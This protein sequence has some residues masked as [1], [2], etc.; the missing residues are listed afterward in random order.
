VKVTTKTLAARLNLSHSTV[1]MALREHPLINYK[2][3]LRVQ[4]L[5]REMNYRPNAIARAMRSSMT[6][7]IGVLVCTMDD[8]FTAGVVNAIEHG[9]KQVDYQSILCQSHDSPEAL[10]KEIQLLAERRVDGL[11][12]HPFGVLRHPELP[13]LLRSLDIPHVFYDGFVEGSSCV[14]SDNQRMGRLATEH[15]L[16]LGHREIAFLGGPPDALN[17]IGR[18][19]GYC[20]ALE[21]ADIPFDPALVKEAGWHVE[22]GGASVEALLARGK[23]FSAIVAGNDL[24]AIGAIKALHRR[25]LSVPR[26]V[27]VTGAGDC[28]VTTLFE[29]AVTT[30]D[31]DIKEMGAR[32]IELLMERIKNPAA[33]PR[34]VMI[35]CAMIVRETTAS[36]LG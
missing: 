6:K 22:D 32:T 27:S 12:I 5:A 17:S 34:E 3:R 33:P 24:I 1:S 13:K 29:P 18:R 15:L 35:N 9:A 36:K 2:T 25:G 16:G 4:A 14:R 8:F 28:S 19:E 11:V 30:V 10:E 20:A 31:Q 26:D 7:T 21:D 23:K